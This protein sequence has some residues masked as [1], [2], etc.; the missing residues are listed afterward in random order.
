LVNSLLKRSEVAS[1]LSSHLLLE[2]ISY[3]DNNSSK[4]W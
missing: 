1:S 3:L 2:I 4:R